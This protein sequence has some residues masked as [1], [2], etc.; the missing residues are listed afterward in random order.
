MEEAC[1][2]PRFEG[3]KWGKKER[4]TGRLTGKEGLACWHLKSNTRGKYRKNRKAGRTHVV[5]KEKLRKGEMPSKQKLTTERGG[6]GKFRAAPSWSHAAEGFKK[7]KNGPDTDLS[8]G[9]RCRSGL[10]GLWVKRGLLIESK[11]NSIGSGQ[12]NTGGQAY[13]SR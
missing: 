9:K 5:E 3:E 7:I 1:V 4:L 10:Q 6:K 8:G 11:L 13:I 2:C 12:K